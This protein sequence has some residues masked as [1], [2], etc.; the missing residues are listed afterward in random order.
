MSNHSN[1][2]G[3]EGGAFLWYGSSSGTPDNADRLLEK[4][5]SYAYFGWSVAFAGNVNGDAHDDVIVGAPS[6][7]QAGEN[8]RWRIMRIAAS[9]PKRTY[10]PPAFTLIELLVVIGVIAILASL[11]LAALSTAKERGLR[12]LCRSNLRQ[13]GVAIQMYAGDNHDYFPDNTGTRLTVIDCGTTVQAFWR[14]YLLPLVQTPIEKDRNHVLFCP[15]DRWHRRMDMFQWTGGEHPL[16]CG[17]LHLP[18]RNTRSTNWTVGGTGPWHTRQRLG[19]EFADAPVVVDR[20]MSLLE[21]KA[22][23]LWIS[24]E[25]D[26]RL[27]PFSAHAGRKGEPL[28]GNFLFADGHVVWYRRARIEVASQYANSTYFFYRVPIASLQP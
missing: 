28:G 16:Y 21:G 27:L 10:P 24:R 9:N 2:Q 4:N 13:W 17:Y 26:T 23:M 15:T 7:D 8:G 20:L 19:G 11:L 25:A 18:Y 14:H 12:T 3:Y 22:D 1:G 5:Q 6:Y